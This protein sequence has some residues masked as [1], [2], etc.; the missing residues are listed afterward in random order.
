MQVPTTDRDAIVAALDDYDWQ[1]VFEYAGETG[2]N[3]PLGSQTVNP[4]VPGCKVSLNGFTRLDVAEVI[5]IDEGQND[6]DAW[7]LAGRLDDGRWFVLEAWCDYTGW[8]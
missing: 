2:E 4:C 5:Y 8:D 1:S 6:G 7:V 3:P